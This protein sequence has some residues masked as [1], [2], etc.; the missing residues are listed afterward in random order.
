MIKDQLRKQLRAVRQ[1]HVASLPD[2]MRT[3]VF[4]RPPAPLLDLVPEGA[5]IGL[6]RANPHEVAFFDS[7]PYNENGPGHSSSESGAWSN[8]PFFEDGLVIFTSVREG[9]FIMRVSPPPVS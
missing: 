9:L 5:T 2:S 8:Y 4:M 3:L 7:A 6:Y 1:E